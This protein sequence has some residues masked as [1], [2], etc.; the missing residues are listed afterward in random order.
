MANTTHDPNQGPPDNGKK[1]WLDEKRNVAKIFWGLGLV[2]AGLGAADFFYDKQIHFEM[3]EVPTFFAIFGFVVC[4]GLV[5]GAK[6]LRKVL[7]RDQ[8]YYDR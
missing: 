1:H 7:K 2:C 8:D 6:E 3:E 5:L 4:V